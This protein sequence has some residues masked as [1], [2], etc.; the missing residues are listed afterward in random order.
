MFQYM[1]RRRL[2]NG[3]VDVDETCFP[4]DPEWEKG[5]GPKVLRRDRQWCIL[6]APWGTLIQR[7]ARCRLSRGLQDPTKPH[8]RGLGQP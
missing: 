4:R 1:R 5:A 8:I 6:E 2:H 7:F 3:D